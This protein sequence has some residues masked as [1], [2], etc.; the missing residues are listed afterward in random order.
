MGSVVQRR[1]SLETWWQRLLPLDRKRPVRKNWFRRRRATWTKR[2]LLQA[3]GQW[4]RPKKRA[5]ARW[6]GSG[7]EKRPPLFLYQTSLIAFCLTAFFDRPHWPRAWNRLG[8]RGL[9]GEAREEKFAWWKTVKA[10][11]NIFAFPCKTK[12]ETFSFNVDIISRT[13]IPI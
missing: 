4:G 12:K 2:S 5:C 7:K 6:A 11:S 8:K 3:L 1:L 10:L 13:Q 9:K